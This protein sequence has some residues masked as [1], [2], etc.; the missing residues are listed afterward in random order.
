M[1][2]KAESPATVVKA[3]EMKSVK[4]DSA[5]RLSKKAKEDGLEADK[6]KMDL[7][8]RQIGEYGIEAMGKLIKMRILICGARGL[9]IEIAKNLV[10]AG[11]GA[12]TIYDPEACT[13]SDLGLNFFLTPEDV[14]QGMPRGKASSTQL[15]KLN[16]LV[17]V[18]SIAQLSEDLVA[19]H[20]CMVVTRMNETESNRWNEF[21]R[22][23]GIGFIKTDVI[24]PAGYV[25]VDFGKEF[26]VRDMNG[27]QPVTRIVTHISNDRE[28]VVSLVPFPDGRRHNLE[29]SDHDGYVTFEEVEGMG[30]EINSKP[31][32][33]KH[34]Y[35]KRV[36]AKTGKEIQQFDPYAFSIDFDTTNCGKY[37]G[38][39]RMTQHK[40]PVLFSFKSLKESIEEPGE[41]LFTDGAKFGRAEQLHAA[42]RALWRFQT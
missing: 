19:S 37:T 6:H 24:G 22:T 18:K 30:P 7:Y 5:D 31:F 17:E 23:K 29:M 9:G 4:L 41:L 39:G 10:L 2:S 3:G 11:P 14:K 38:G 27:E 34:V 21:C 26:Y 16:R 36:D 40:R 32:K 12:V 35:K 28:A 13:M 42:F 1:K 8:S 20:T 15:Q 33:I 25:F